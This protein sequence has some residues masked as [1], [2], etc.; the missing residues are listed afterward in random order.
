MLLKSFILGK[1]G[2]AAD[3]GGMPKL[4]EVLKPGKHVDANGVGVEF[5]EQD[6]Q[7]IAA[8]YD[9]GVFEAP[10]VVGHPRLDSPSYG[11]AKSFVVQGG[12]L[13]ADPDQVEPQ[14]AEMVT[15]GRFKKV[16]LAL[17][18]PKSAGNPKPGH[19][20]PKHIGFLGAHAPAIKGLKSVSFSEADEYFTFGEGY[21]N[22]L[23]VQALKGLREWLI[24]DRGQEAADRALPAYLI[25]AAQEQAITDRVTEQLEGDDAT[26]AVPSFSEPPRKEPPMSTAD[27]AAD[28]AA[29]NARNAKL[30]SELDAIKARDAKAAQDKIA[31]D[32]VAFAEGLVSQAR[33][34]AD[35]KD[36]VVAMYTTLATPNADGQVVV[37]GEGEAAKP[38]VELFKGLLGA[39]APAVTFGEHA[40]RGASTEGQSPEVIAQRATEYRAEQAAKGKHITLPDAINHVKANP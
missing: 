10:I 27:L 33:L 2:A 28:V 20:Y 15:S 17:Y 4:I 7:S 37:F 21:V 22:S 30:Q 38:V 5:T 11:W 18:G 1:R 34:P 32:A 12:L 23:F 39:A 25:D 24:G 14:F 29:L 35:H 40:K 26:T 19:W 6:L 13:C 31:A 9:P 36:A 8:V 16:S 3:T